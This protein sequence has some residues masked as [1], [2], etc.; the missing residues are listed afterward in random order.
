MKKIVAFS[1]LSALLGS[2]AFAPAA[3]AQTTQ[4]GQPAYGR[5]VNTA[6]GANA[7]PAT[8]FEGRNVYAA[9][10]PA[11]G[12]EPYIARQIEADQRSR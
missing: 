6:P 7:A 11:Q 4:A 10:A 5:T 8:V 9:P 1:L 2:I 12:V 3:V